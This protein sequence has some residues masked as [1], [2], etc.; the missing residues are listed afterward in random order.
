M[1]VVLSAL[2]VTTFQPREVGEGKL[3]MNQGCLQTPR[4]SPGGV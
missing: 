4:Y 1:V 3:E 2:S